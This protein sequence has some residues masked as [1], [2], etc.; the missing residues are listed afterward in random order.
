MPFSKDPEMQKRQLANLRPPPGSN[1]ERRQ[2]A[3]L[4]RGKESSGTARPGDARA[5]MHGARTRA[6]QRSVEWG[7]AVEAAILDLQPCIGEELRDEHGDVF[8]WAAPAVEALALSRLTAARMER[9]VA[10]RCAKGIATGTDFVM[11]TKVNERYEDALRAQ[12]MTLPSRLA[13][14]REAMAL[15]DDLAL[16]WA[17]QDARERAD[18]Q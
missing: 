14:H 15:D 9:W 16:R 5:L 2:K 3:G 18:G 1:A 13:A 11:A 10:D 12:A 6:P 17:R 7:P 4:K 8:V